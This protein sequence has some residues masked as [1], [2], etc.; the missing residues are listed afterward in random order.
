M[1][2]ML[3]V[4]EFCQA[5]QNDWTRVVFKGKSTIYSLV[6]GLEVVVFSIGTYIEW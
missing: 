4:M 2:P 1:S 6:N 5:K 3:W